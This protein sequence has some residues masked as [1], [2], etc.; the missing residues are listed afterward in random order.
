M[1]AFQV[2]DDTQS[3]KPLFLISGSIPYVTYHFVSAVIKD[4]KLIILNNPHTYE[5]SEDLYQVY[6]TAIGTI[7]NLSDKL[8]YA[9]F[10]LSSP[11]DKKT[12][13]QLLPKLEKDS[14]RT[15]IVI[16]VS[17]YLEYLDVV[18]QTKD[19]PFISYAFVGDVFGTTIPPESSYI[20]HVIYTA[21]TQKTAEFVGSELVSIFP[22]SL[23]DSGKGLQYLL[24]SKEKRERI[25]FF[26]Y[27]HPQTIIS[28][29]HIL[30]RL[31]SDLQIV[32]GSF[33]QEFSLLP[34]H[35]QLEKNI[36]KKTNLKSSYIDDVLEG[37]EKGIRQTSYPQTI[38]KKSKKKRKK[39]I[40]RAPSRHFSFPTTIT[41]F[42]CS[43]LLFL[44]LNIMITGAG[45]LFAKQ[46]VASFQHGEFEQAGKKFAIAKESFETA[47]PVVSLGFEILQK[48][49]LPHIS[50]TYQMFMSGVTLTSLAADQFSQLDAIQNKKMTEDSLLT[51]IATLSY[52]YFIAQSSPHSM[53]LPYINS[54]TDPSTSNLLATADVLPEVLGYTK[55]KTYLI[56][57][58]NNGELRP[59]GGFIGSVG[60]LRVHNGQVEDFTIQDV[61]DIDGQIKTH[62]EPPFVVR[63]YLQPHLYLRDSNF[64]LDFQETA[65]TAA[66]LYKEGG[67]HVVDGVIAIDYDVLKKIIEITGPLHLPTYNKTIDEKNGFDFIQSTIQDTFTPGNSQKKGIL[68]EVFAQIVFKLE[69]TQTVFKI[70]TALPKLIEEKHILFAF[71]D[72]LLQEIFTVQKYGGTIET[73]GT[74]DKNTLYDYFSVNE[75][76]IGVNKANIQ[77]S[78]SVSLI[79]KM[80]SSAITT[81]ATLTLDNTKG[82]EPYKVFIQFIA[83]E[84]SSFRSL[85]INGKNTPTTPAITSSRLYESPS[86]SLPKDTELITEEYKDKTIFGFIYTV[87]AGKKDSLSL[88]YSRDISL[89]TESFEYD[90]TYQKQ[91]GTSAYPFELSLE[92]PNTFTAH[93]LKTGSIA[94]KKFSSSQLITKDVDIHVSFK[95]KN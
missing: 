52:L 61:Y 48:L 36:Q 28:A 40:K 25:F 3:T 75:A 59:T 49:P 17:Q 39:K 24:F 86:F 11:D 66:L 23:E 58:Q 31:D 80:S 4:F 37:F 89:P 5:A 60:E 27:E 8:N 32:S 82:D 72:P 92:F 6:T 22:I 85:V 68:S 90:M 38:T 14:P 1:S 93:D 33:P 63:R 83:P 81:I 15:I 46:A 65:T 20:S 19:L 74:S 67:G 47:Q 54:F 50:D 76:N 13:T 62:V 53:H 45:I 94:Q 95:E 30:K 51:S 16:P 12:L 69:N 91:P 42:M 57:F 43:I 55:E 21:K 79:Q 26:F 84:D 44:I 73:T 56:L 29:I 41:I 88:Q 18:E 7:K 35:A 10:F 77:I 9:V 64:S 70:A 71:K 34:G 78:R 2:S 87:E